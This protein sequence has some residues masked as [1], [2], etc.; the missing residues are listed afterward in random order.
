MCFSFQICCHLT[1]SHKQEFVLDISPNFA[2][3]SVIEVCPLSVS[4]PSCVDPPLRLIQFTV[5]EGVSIFLTQVREEETTQINLS[6]G[7]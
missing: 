1:Y 7:S 4:A 2:P 6:P 3:Q 5:C